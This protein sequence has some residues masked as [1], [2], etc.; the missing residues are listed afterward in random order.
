[1]SPP[2][3]GNRLLAALPEN[4]YARLR[5]LLGHVPLAFGTVLYEPGDAIHFVYFPHGGMVSLLSS[6]GERATLEVGLVGQEG[7]VGLPLFLGV[8]TSAH[9]TLVQ[10]AGEAAVL[11]AGAFVTAVERSRTLSR[12]LRRYTHA[13]LTELAQ[14]LVCNHFH[15]IEARLARWLLLA[16]DRMQTD[17]MQL[18]Q[19][20]LAQMLGVRREA[21]TRTAG[22]LAARRLIRYHH[23]QLTILD[24]PGLEAL[25]CPC[26]RLLR[27]EDERFERDVRDGFD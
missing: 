15:P 3:A 16:H 14:R 10:G 5:P 25:A 1:M 8:A 24:R 6:A 18:T 21:V 17:E 11:E 4:E 7:I 20:L 2:P 22:G 23:G 19:A 27:A 13:Q 26:Y 12:L 9:H